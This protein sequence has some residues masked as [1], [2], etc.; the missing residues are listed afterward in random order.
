MPEPCY[1]TIH[2]KSIYEAVW[3]RTSRRYSN[4]A[5]TG[6]QLSLHPK[7]WLNWPR[8]L[9]RATHVRQTKAPPCWITAGQ[10]I[11][12]AVI[13]LLFRMSLAAP[14]PREGSLAE[15]PYFNWKAAGSLLLQHNSEVCRTLIMRR[16]S[17]T[18]RCFLS[19]R[20][21]RVDIADV[22]IAGTR[23]NPAIYTVKPLCCGGPF[24]ER[25]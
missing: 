4:S 3:P 20:C 22:V 11:G 9:V 6:S 2:L 19:I 15:R 25:H 23:Q 7:N 14:E 12:P 18:L 17:H 16:N 24:R 8:H 21:W 13:V 5:R 1:S 10:L